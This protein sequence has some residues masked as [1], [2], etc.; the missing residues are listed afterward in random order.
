MSKTK[1]KKTEPSLTS[2][3]NRQE[4]SGSS[5]PVQKEII[6][7]YCVLDAKVK[8]S[9]MEASGKASKLLF[10]HNKRVVAEFFKSKGVT[11]AEVTF[12]GY[13]D[14]GQIESVTIKANDKNVTDELTDKKVDDYVQHVAVGYS[15]GDKRKHCWECDVTCQ[16]AVEDICYGILQSN[17][18]GWEINGGS[19]GVFAFVVTD[20]GEL[21]IH[22]DMNERVED[23]VY[24][25]GNY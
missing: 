23:T 19:F 6:K 8:D 22:L 11:S 5:T 20:E 12:D 24:S 10:A 9:F 16:S 3:F 13:G 1:T 18:C 25:E 15:S 17:H 2:L 21:K 14:S 4:I 7:E